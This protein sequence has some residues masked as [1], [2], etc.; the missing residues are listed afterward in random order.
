MKRWRL[1]LTSLKYI[2]PVDDPAQ[3]TARAVLMKRKGGAL[4]GIEA[5]AKVVKREDGTLLG[6]DLG[7]VFGWACTSKASGT[8]YFD[9]HGDNIVED[10]LIKVALEY[11]KAGAQSDEMHNRETDGWTPFVMPLTAELAKRAGIDTDTSGILIG[12][13]PSPEVFAKFKSGE[14][15]GFSI[16][17]TGFREEVLDKSKRVQKSALYT[18]VVDGHQHVICIWDD[19][20]MH[21]EWAT[22]EGASATH[23][24]GIVRGEN[25]AIE[26]LLDSGHT[27]QLAAGQPSVVVVPEDA[28]VV[29]QA[30][31]S[32]PHVKTSKVDTMKT[33]A[34]KIADLEKQV[35]DLTKRSERAER[36]AKMTGA[37]KAH[38]DTLG[39]DA[40]D[41]FLA[42]S[43]S[44]RDLVI[45]AA[46]DADPVEVE[47]DG[48]NYRKSMGAGVIALAKKA[49]EQAEALEKA[50]VRKAAAETIGAL[51][52]GDEI[53]DFIVRAVRKS[54]SKEQ[55]EAA[56]TAMR[57]WNDIAKT[58]AT[59]PGIG[60]TDPT[61]KTAQDNWDAAVAK[62]M[63]DH[64]VDKSTA[65][66][67]LMDTPEGARL[68]AEV[69]KAIRAK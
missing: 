18:D 49:K 30:S 6:G 52:G 54:G 19:G 40:A 2:S 65:T 5:T 46:L 15:V 59:A 12:M 20:A 47:F 33:D 35:S 32:T 56:L 36:I 1:K 43:A 25:G 64:K 29:V 21:V 4:P 62:R 68:Y 31:K 69:A 3:E 44:D 60:G 27:H 7:I 10:D 61:D 11:V 9:L 57:G 16:D 26:I 24:H 51:T 39:S 53:H 41:E 67:Q 38:F 14:Y 48:V 58:K 50:D 45:K 34:D 17:G 63:A 23:S 55:V 8:D 13:Q 66:V 28:I 42:K 37:Q 22:A